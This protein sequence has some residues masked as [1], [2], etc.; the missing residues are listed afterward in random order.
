MLYTV[1]SPWYAPLGIADLFSDIVFHVIIL[2]IDAFLERRDR[3]MF[4]LR[5][6][7]KAQ[8]R[9]T[10]RAQ[11]AEKRAADLKKRFASYSQCAQN[12]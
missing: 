4:E 7:L 10:Q 8:F 1:R 2:I 5:E 9:A 3:Q 6:Q 11:L 12:H